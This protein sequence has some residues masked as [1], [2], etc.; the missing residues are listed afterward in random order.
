MVISDYSLKYD[1]V[2]EVV[3]C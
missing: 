2:R 3:G 1:L